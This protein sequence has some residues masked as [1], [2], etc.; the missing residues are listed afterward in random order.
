MAADF[1]TAA[2]M[3]GIMYNACHGGFAFSE[4]AVAEYNRRKDPS[5]PTLDRL[6]H[7]LD[8]T[9][10]L[11]IEICSDMRYDANGLY[12]D[13]KVEY[14]PIR[15]KDHFIITEDS[16]IES[17]DIDYN[18]YTLDKIRGILHNDVIANDHKIELLLE[19]VNAN[20]PSGAFSLE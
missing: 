19:I 1:T 10:P 7:G 11:M 9:D 16:G 8:R 5:T 12:A 13:I 3:I 6:A 4:A 18:G 15:Y 14:I 20:F 2:Q 17:V